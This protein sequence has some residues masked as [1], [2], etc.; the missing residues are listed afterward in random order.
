[1][2]DSDYADELE[3][4]PNTAA[5]IESLLTSLEQAT[6]RIGVFVNKNQKEFMSFKPEGA[7]SN[8]NVR[9]LKLID[10]FRCLGSNILST[11]IYGLYGGWGTVLMPILS[12]YP[13]RRR[14]VQSADDQSYG[15]L[16]SPIK[17]NWISSKLWLCRYNC[18]DAPHRC[19]QSAWRWNQKWN[20]KRLLH[21]VLNKSWKQH[22][23]KQLL[24]TTASEK[25]W[26]T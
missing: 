10:E 11:E 20:Y 24:Y 26:P 17:L 4:L 1:M 3:L 19:K 7:I 22:P 14:G 25:N 5:L 2:T 23:T 16:I 6:G 18:M 21:V 15:N 12:T 13:Q 9:P 8:L